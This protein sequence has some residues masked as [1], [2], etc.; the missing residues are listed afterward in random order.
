MSKETSTFDSFW[1][2]SINKMATLEGELKESALETCKSIP[3]E[4]VENWAKS[5]I[6][7]IKTIKTPECFD[8]FC[9]SFIISLIMWTLDDVNSRLNVLVEIFNNAIQ[10]LNVEKFVGYL[11]EDCSAI[12]SAAEAESP[13]DMNVFLGI[14]SPVFAYCVGHNEHSGKVAEIWFYA[15]CGARGTM[16]FG[17][18][19]Q[20]ALN[21]FKLM[22]HAFFQNAVLPISPDIAPGEAVEQSFLDMQKQIR[23]AIA[24]IANEIDTL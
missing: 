4:N 16:I 6:S 1:Q 23:S 22:N 14:Q 3:D 10:E 17:E 9:H 12:F 11:L 24:A 18:N 5:G 13:I 7:K 19:K 21:Y 15:I 8:A 2:D 20:K